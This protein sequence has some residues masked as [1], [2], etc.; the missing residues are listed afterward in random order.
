MQLETGQDHMTGKLTKAERTKLAAHA[1][2]FD[3]LAAAIHSKTRLA[4]VS[5]LAA[6]ESLSFVEL[7]SVLGLTDGNLAAHLHAL[8]RAGMIRLRKVG[9]QPKP[10]TVASLS[11]AGRNAFRRHLEGLEHILKCHR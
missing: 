5:V 9:A 6:R 2:A 8:D 11:A 1:A 10:I 7:R 3:K 4:I